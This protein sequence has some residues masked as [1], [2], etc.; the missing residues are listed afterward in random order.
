MSGPKFFFK[1]S[2]RKGVPCLFPKLAEPSHRPVGGTKWFLTRCL[3]GALAWTL[4][5]AVCVCVIWFACYWCW[6]FAP[7]S[8]GDR[9]KAGSGGSG[10]TVT[11]SSPVSSLREAGIDSQQGSELAR[12][13][14]APRCAT[15]KSLPLRGLLKSLSLEGQF[16]QY[17]ST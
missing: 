4:R 10:G 16:N 2:Q 11:N 5:F 14:T 7:D 8:F 12:V 13:V 6:D 17:R 9:L 3:A 15:K 1:L